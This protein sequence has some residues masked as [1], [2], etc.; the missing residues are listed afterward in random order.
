ML[1]GLF[2]SRWISPIAL[3]LLMVV[4]SGSGAGWAQG[5]APEIIKGTKK[6][7]GETAPTIKLKEEQKAEPAPELAKDPDYQQGLKYHQAGKYDQ[8]VKALKKAQKKYPSAAELHYRLGLAQAAQGNQDQARASFEEALRLKP[9]Y[10]EARGSLGELYSQQGI[11]LLEKGDPTRAEAQLKEALS[12]NPQNDRA[13]SHLG[14]AL[15]QQERWSEAVTALRQAVDLNP[16]NVEAQ[17]NL[18]VAYYLM[19]DKDGASQQYAVTTLLDPEAGEELFRLI[20]GTSQ[21][22]TPF[23]F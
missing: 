13:Y 23:R 16:N 3:G 9:D 4:L 2:M 8:A 10:Q 5:K 7:T 17:Y 12:L 20:Q 18:G 11:S 21:T 6:V 1:C 15:A 14:V 19:G 22:A